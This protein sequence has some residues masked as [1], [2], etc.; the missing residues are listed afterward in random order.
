MHSF[1]S[2]WEGR[3]ALTKLNI[4]QLAPITTALLDKKRCAEA[5]FGEARAGRAR[6]SWTRPG[7]SAVLGMLGAALGI[8]WED[9]QAH[10]ALSSGLGYAVRTDATG[11]SLTD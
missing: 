1:D 5:T 4:G 7:R 8:D 9:L 6:Q 3:R 2:R 11:H 10:A